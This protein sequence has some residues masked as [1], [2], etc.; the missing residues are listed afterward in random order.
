MDK[1]Q[2]RQL[3]VLIVLGIALVSGAVFLSDYLSYKNITFTLSS[4]TKSIQVYS[5]KTKVG[6]VT[7]PGSMRLKTG[8]Y[9]V[10]PSGDGIDTSPI[11]VD[12]KK[13]TSSVTIDPFLTSQRLATEFKGELDAIRTAL[14]KKYSDTKNYFI[15]P[16][17]F[18]H[19]GDWYGSVI[20]Y[21]PTKHA[22][23]NVDMFGIILHKVNNTWEVAATPSIVFS[24]KNCPDIPKDIV[25]AVNKAVS[26]F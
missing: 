7:G 5:G 24:Y 16:G 6:D 13:D 23:P 21:Y 22:V 10:Q 17:N 19:H 20:F 1:L 2:L 18:Y 14:L 26:N 12:V 8:S 9:V 25:D 3:T 15:A 4:N 11:V